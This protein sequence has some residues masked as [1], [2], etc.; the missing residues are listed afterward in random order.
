MAATVAQSIPYVPKY[1]MPPEI[2][3]LLPVSLGGLGVG[4][5]ERVCGGE[6]VCVCW[7][8]TS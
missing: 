8:E 2:D 6:G 7:S 3:S 5:C 4:V 1:L